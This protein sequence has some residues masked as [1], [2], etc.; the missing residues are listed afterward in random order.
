M[1]HLLDV[2]TLIALIWPSHVH[3]AQARA[4]LKGK[5]IVLCPLAELGFVRVATSEAFNATMADAR[6]ELAD[7]IADEKPGFVAADIRALDGTSAPNSGKSTDWYLA[8]LAV[9][10]GMKWATLDGKA[11]HP[12]TVLARTL[13][14]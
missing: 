1:K 3:Y 5:S 10:H 11:K 9:H 4:W 6:Q 2:S 13:S 8:N 7:F 12:A 14:H